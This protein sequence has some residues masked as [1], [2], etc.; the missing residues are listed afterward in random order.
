MYGALLCAVLLGALDQLVFATALPTIVGELHGMADLS[1]VTTSYVVASTITLPVYGKLGDQFGRR[2]LFIVALV[3]FVS[4]SA[5]GILASGMTV[6]IIARTIQGLG[7]GGI[8][9]LA[10]ALIA[11]QV[12]ARRRGPYLG[13]ISAMWAL[14]SV[15]GPVLGGFF[16]EG[17]GW[18]WALAIN[19]P[20]GL[21]A[22]TATITL[23]PGR[24]RPV[25]RPR[26]D[27][28]G[29]L[30]LGIGVVSLIL[31]TTRGGTDGWGSPTVVGLGIGTLAALV[32][33][34]LVE[35]RVADPILPPVLF[36]NRDFLIATTAGV[37]ASLA[38]FGVVGYLP[39]W[40]QMASSTGATASGL[41]MMP[42]SLG[43]FGASILGGTAIAKTGRYRELPVAAAIGMAAGLWILA[44]TQPA[45]SP[46]VLVIAL[47][48]FGGGLGLASQAWTL[49][50]QN[51]APRG[52]V[53]IATAA[54]NFLNQIG[55][56]LGLALVGSVFAARLADLVATRTA[57]VA[58]ADGLTLASLSP[59]SVGAMPPALHALVV[60]AYQ[61]ALV[62]VYGVL[63]PIV[64]VIAALALFLSRRPLATTLDHGVHNAK[65]AA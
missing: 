39:T 30:I 29:A 12:P 65:S 54:N 10:M 4:G 18:R 31:F 49:V 3:V 50:V 28:L 43:I 64:L 8:G 51:G 60:G 25:D 2:P 55:S 58:G 46:W 44:G 37:I 45:T 21:L 34:V 13:M 57:G 24:P 26:F 14:A 6:L 11:D 62:P 48:L 32:V 7:G 38:M 63:A 61:D 22:L 42:V 27:A 23:M 56:S 33:F 52:Q 35:R 16:A 17:I 47:L 36:T 5:I 20:F 40:L 19:I 59:A 15:L 53:G 41:T 1:W 9:V